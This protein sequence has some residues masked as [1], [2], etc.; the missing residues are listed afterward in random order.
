APDSGGEKE[1]ILPHW[2]YL[3]N[4]D[5]LLVLYG[6]LSDQDDFSG[7]DL[8]QSVCHSGTAVGT[9]NVCRHFFC[10]L[11]KTEAEAESCE[12]RLSNSSHGSALHSDVS[13]CSLDV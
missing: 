13:Y 5:P 2:I 8:Q 9:A 3:V 11:S 6:C 4:D 7:P 12:T 1:R 10:N